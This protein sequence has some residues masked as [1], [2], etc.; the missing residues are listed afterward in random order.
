MSVASSHPAQASILSSSSVSFLDLYL[1]SFP[2]LDPGFL[3][4][5]SPL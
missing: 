1:P 3:S 4:H 5:L 2:G